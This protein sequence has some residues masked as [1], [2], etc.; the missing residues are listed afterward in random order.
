MDLLLKIA[1][2]PHVKAWLSSPCN[3]NKCCGILATQKVNGDAHQIPEPWSGDI[4]KAP[5]LFLSSNPSIDEYSIYP[6]WS[7]PDDCVKDYFSNRF[8]Q[9][10]ENGIRC[11]NHDGSRTTVRFWA[12]V[13]ARAKELLDRE[14]APGKDYALTEV[15]HC[16]S[17]ME[18]GVREVLG[19]CATHYLRPIV[20]AS[21]AKIIVVL[22]AIADE[23]VRKEF[24]IPDG[25]RLAG[26]VEIG[27]NN[28]YIVFMPHPNARTV[29][30]FKSCLEHEQLLTLMVF[31]RN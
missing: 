11:V 27:P 1:R 15:V 7:W 3:S 18:G 22:G 17:R 21:G 2:C 29:R 5:I 26:P 9:W 4:M 19:E 14:P 8:E 6:V 12:S 10:I 20:E 23:A 31:L 13:K 30:T 28:R 25:P 16:K 24:K